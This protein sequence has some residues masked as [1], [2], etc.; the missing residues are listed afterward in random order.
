MTEL[1]LLELNEVV[2]IDESYG[3]SFDRQIQDVRDLGEVSSSSSKSLFIKSNERVNNLFGSIFNINADTLN[4]DTNVK[5][6]C[7]IAHDGEILAEGYFQIVEIDYVSKGEYVYNIMVFDEQT[8]FFTSIEENEL[9]DLDFSQYNHVYNLA[10]LENS[11]ANDVYTLPYIY[12]LHNSQVNSYWTEIIDFRIGFYAKWLVD[13]IFT[14][15]GYKYESDFL[16]SDLFKELVIPYSSNDGLPNISQE[17]IDLRKFEIEGDV[18]CDISFSTGTVNIVS[19]LSNESFPN[20]A[21]GQGSVI[22]T[23]QLATPTDQTVGST[24]LVDEGTCNPSTFGDATY[25]T[26]QKIG[27]HNIHF[28]QPVSLEITNYNNFDLFPRDTPANLLDRSKCWIVCEL[29]RRTGAGNTVSINENTLIN[30][31]LSELLENVYIPIDLVKV[32]ANQIITITDT[33]NGV[34]ENITV[35][36]NSEYFV[37]FQVSR[38][39]YA[40]IPNGVS[41]ADVDFEITY[42]GDGAKIF[43]EPLPVEVNE[44]STININDFL[45]QN[46]KQKDFLKS[47]NK[48]FNL[49]WQPIGN[50]TIQIEP[51]DDFYSKGNIIDLRNNDEFFITKKPSQ[52]KAVNELQKKEIVFKYKDDSDSSDDTEM[53]ERRLQKNYFDSFKEYYG[54]QRI[55]FENENLRGERIIEP[56]FSPTIPAFSTQLGVN[57]RSYICSLIDSRNPKCNYRIL[58]V[59]R[60]DQDPPNVKNLKKALKIYD[61]NT[62][63]A[64]ENYETVYLN[65]LVIGTHYRTNPFSP[66]F[67]L[68]YG[69]ARQ[70]LFETKGIDNNL[71]NNY[72]INEIR[73]INTSK[74]IVASFYISNFE[75]SK[76]KLNDILYFEKTEYSNYFMIN[77]I[78][79]Y[80]AKTGEAKMELITYEPNQ[81]F[82]TPIIPTDDI[83]V[84]GFGSVPKTTTSNALPKDN[85]GTDFNIINGQNNNIN[86]GNIVSGNNNIAGKSAFILG[87]DNKVNNSVYVFGNNNSI[88]N[89]K[90]VLIVGNSY[91]DDQVRDNSIVADNIITKS[92][93]NQITEI[94]SSRQ[95]EISETI[96]IINAGNLTITLPRM[97][98]CI[99]VKYIIKSNNSI[100][101]D[102]E[103]DLAD[104]TTIDGSSSISIGSY[105]GTMLINN[106]VEWFII[107]NK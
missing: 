7:I 102:V 86:S 87:S 33:L 53:L 82:T 26:P 16:N 39:R 28:Q 42:E 68:N 101:I 106:G 93:S 17:E 30:S 62:P 97:S 15:Y 11:W 100:N 65:D 104:A 103:P 34:F 36:P 57:G 46:F 55:K 85:S 75:Y 60:L 9:T 84:G 45:P 66:T 58:F 77:K 5:Q 73:S 81:N 37:T 54:Q 71:F 107:S 24:D 38:F 59:N 72:W 51:R 67:D 14:S 61:T 10:S 83:I 20:P 21:I 70:T 29:R 64:G 90:N 88:E 44:G 99:G 52:Y 92:I 22:N 94:A 2:Q 12:L 76:L 1:R 23:A 79:E 78:L 6:N 18:S 63:D 50:K 56:E 41:N 74:M 43:N 8:D 40:S 95:L 31:S 3:V 89:K 69:R 49:K 47:L 105:D 48:M 19:L 13:Y 32:D 35:N 96:V 27:L 98:L 80:N 4:F 25:W 91:Q